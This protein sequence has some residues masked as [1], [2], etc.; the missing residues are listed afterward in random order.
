MKIKMPPILLA[1]LCSFCFPSITHARAPK[2]IDI[3]IQNATQ[4]ISGQAIELTVIFTPYSKAKRYDVEITASGVLNAHLQK[5]LAP[6]PEDLSLSFFVATNQKSS[7]GVL[8]ITVTGINNSG[9]KAYKS[10]S[11]LYAE[12]GGNKIYLSDNSKLH[13]ELATKGGSTKKQSLFEASARESNEEIKHREPR[14]IT[15]DL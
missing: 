1:S 7:S 2:P 5:T 12:R 14:L 11:Y 15:T 4:V 6:T 10:H 8:Q 9:E 13:A 3:N